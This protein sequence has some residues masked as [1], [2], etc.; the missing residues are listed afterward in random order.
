MLAPD[1]EQHV[2]LI[3]A[4]AARTRCRSCEAAGLLPVLDLGMQPLANRLVRE[5]DAGHREPR[6]PLDL[7]FCSSCALLQ[8]TES[9]SPELLFGDYPYFSSVIP[10]L[11]AHAKE[12]AE[13]LVAERGLGSDSLAMEIA[14]N[15]G[16]LLQH[17]RNAGVPVLGIDPARNIAAV[18]EGHGIPTRCAFFGREVATELVAAGCRPDVVHANNV[19]AHVPDLNGF[20]AGIATLIGERGSLVTE[21]PYLKDFLDGLPVRH[22]LPRAPAL[23]LAHRA[24]PAV[25]AAMAW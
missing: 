1:V 20:T 21:S 15:D 4:R 10:S 8:I 16:Y 24:R 23:L 9:V 13:R 25:L 22:D 18:A 17:Y 14:S 11:V 19:L 7:V 6:F 12:I 5:S 2:E 3:R